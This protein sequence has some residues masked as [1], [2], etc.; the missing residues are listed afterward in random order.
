MFLVRKKYS[1]NRC[2]FWLVG[3]VDGAILLRINMLA[4]ANG[5][6]ETLGLK[7]IIEHHDFGCLGAA[8]NEDA[9]HRKLI[10]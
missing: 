1:A 10:T 6:P 8:V 3:M 2:L 9:M 5:R 4:V 7:A